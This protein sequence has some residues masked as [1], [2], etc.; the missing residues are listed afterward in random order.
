MPGARSVVGLPGAMCIDR[1][2]VYTAAHRAICLRGANHPARP[3]SW[4][5]WG[6]FFNNAQAAVSVQACFDWPLPVERD[7]TGGVA[8]NWC[9]FRVDM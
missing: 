8:S 1:A 5:V 6:Y 9:S 3:F 4:C 2:I 7:W